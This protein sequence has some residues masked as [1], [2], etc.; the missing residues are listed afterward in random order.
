MDTGA[1]SAF[2][3]E[4]NRLCKNTFSVKLPVTELPF[5][6]GIRRTGPFELKNIAYNMRF[7]ALQWHSM[8]GL[9]PS[10]ETQTL[11]LALESG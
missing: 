9:L 5:G 1:R 10:D 6:T 4:I 3:I 2:L 8:T 7:D 11:L